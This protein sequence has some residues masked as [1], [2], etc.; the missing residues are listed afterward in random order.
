MGDRNGPEHAVE[1]E[2]SLSQYDS[3]DRDHVYIGGVSVTAE[4]QF[5]SEILVRVC[6]DLTGDLDALDVEEVEVVNPITS[7]D[8]GTLE[9]DYG[10]YD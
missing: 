1:G 7:V 9:P 4:E 10:E 8:F 6:G 2:F 3:I 5:T